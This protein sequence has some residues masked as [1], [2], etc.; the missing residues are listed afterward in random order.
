LAVLVGQLVFVGTLVAIARGKDNDPRVIIHQIASTPVILSLSGAAWI[1][2]LL[3]AR[4]G[5]LGLEVAFCIVN[6]ISGLAILID[7]GIVEQREVI[8][9]PCLSVG[10]NDSM[11]S[12]EAAIAQGR[13]RHHSTDSIDSFGSQSPG[14][15]VGRTILSSGRRDT[16]DVFATSAI[17]TPASG[18]HNGGR[19]GRW[20]ASREKDNEQ[21][22]YGR[23]DVHIT[24]TLR[25]NETSDEHEAVKSKST[26]SGTHD[27]NQP[28]A[29]PNNGT[30]RII[31]TTDVNNETLTYI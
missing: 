1:I 12:T 21:M 2:G 11:D 26:V 14:G 22:K 5:G 27:V 23:P 16:H 8:L 9:R 18:N 3:A 28:A 6:S 10:N 20:A 7:R 30:Y 25:R 29:A 19:W 4:F 24:G 15:V 17:I 13:R 31:T